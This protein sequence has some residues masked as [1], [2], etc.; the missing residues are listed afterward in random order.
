MKAY[1]IPLFV[2]SMMA[3]AA[4]AETFSNDLSHDTSR[5]YRQQNRIANGLADGS[6]DANEAARLQRDQARINRLRAEMLRDGEFTANERERLDRLQDTQNERIQRQRNDSQTGDPD[7]RMSAGL[8]TSIERNARQQA[9]IDEGLASGEITLREAS[10]L[11]NQQARIYAAQSNALD[12]D[13]FSRQER[14][15]IRDRQRQA[16]DAIRRSANNNRSTADAGDD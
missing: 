13:R 5:E 16:A 12:N 14:R 15:Q 1:F 6:L 4:Q 11:S 3:G 7:T 9:R 10:R 8:Q 2:L